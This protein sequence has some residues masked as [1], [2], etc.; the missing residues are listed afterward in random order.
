MLLALALQ[1]L[2]GPT[3]SPPI[4]DEPPPRPTRAATIAGNTVGVALMVGGGTSAALSTG[5]ATDAS[6]RVFGGALGLAP[7]AGGALLVSYLTAYRAQALHGRD[8]P[9]RSLIGWIG[10]G[11]VT[12]GVGFVTLSLVGV[13]TPLESLAVPGLALLAGGLPLIVVQGVRNGRTRRAGERR[14]PGLAF[15]PGMVRH[16]PGLIVTG[17]L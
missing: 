6:G 14:G 11:V 8:N 2:G 4:L 15:G 13:D 1:A 16:A 12:G 10:A 9:D 5:C 3:S 7:A 17:R